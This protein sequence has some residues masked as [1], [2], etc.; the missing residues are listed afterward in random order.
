MVRL[1]TVG[2]RATIG[3]RDGTGDGSGDP[4]EW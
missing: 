2:V 4:P 3:V 1:S